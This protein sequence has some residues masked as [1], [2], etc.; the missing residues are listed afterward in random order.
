SPPP[1]GSPSG[2]AG[3]W[4]RPALFPLP[5]GCPGPELSRPLLAAACP[6]SRSAV[7][8]GREDRASL[9]RLLLSRLLKCAGPRALEF[10]TTPPRF[11]ATASL[12][13]LTAP[14]ARL[15][16]AEGGPVTNLRHE[17]VALHVLDRQV[18]GHLDGGRDRDQL[19]Q[20]LADEGVRGHLSDLL[21]ESLSRLASRALLVG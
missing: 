15:Q 12:C 18:L 14:L 3:P 9:R 13:P 19:V 4:G 1:G 5:G 2:G 21:D 7:E 17:T 10:R 16:A 20:A 8:Q 11:V 6:R